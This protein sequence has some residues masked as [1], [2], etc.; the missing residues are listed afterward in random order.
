MK[1]PRASRSPEV[2]VLLACARPRLEP[3]DAARLDAAAAGAVDWARLLELAHAHRLSPLLRHHVAAGALPMPSTSRSVLKAQVD[4]NGR[5]ALQLTAALIEVVDACGAAAIPLAPLKG[6]ILAQQLYGS[7]ALRHT[8]DLDL[9]VRHADVPRLVRLLQARGYHLN[10]RDT[11]ELDAFTVQ[12]LHH[13]SVTHPQGVQIEI[14]YWLFRP[15]GRR[16]HG[17]DDIAVRLQ[18]VPFFGRQV[19][20]LEDEA[21]LVYLCEHG[22]EHTWSRLEWLAGMN[23]L[24]RR[25]DAAHAA[26]SAFAHELGS[27]KRVRAAMDLA[28]A[29]LDAGAEQPGRPAR[30][31]FAANRSVIRRW[32]REPG[33]AIGTSAERF[34]YGLLTDTS[35]AAI[36]RRCWT[37]LLAPSIGDRHALPLPRWL[38]PLLWVLRP[39]RLIARQ[40]GQRRTP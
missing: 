29:L 11:P 33:R 18:P 14:H 37:M 31:S 13:V 32:Q 3:E 35:P 7:V 40:L 19:L 4:A 36:L 28:A 27:A 10:N 38:L 26:A 12:D 39:F 23:V 6:P 22:A 5:R 25:T 24:R 34:V 30:P 16:S 8:N 17:F 2:A 15:R 20:V 1:T 9:L 21:L